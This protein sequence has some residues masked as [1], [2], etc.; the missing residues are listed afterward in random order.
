MYCAHCRKRFKPRPWPTTRNKF[1]S[2]RCNRDAWYTRNKDRVNAK[3]RQWCKD[4]RELRLEVQRRWNASSWGKVL[5][6]AW[7][8]DHPRVLTPQERKNNSARSTARR[9]LRRKHPIRR[10]VCRGP[11]RGRIEC[12]HKDGNPLNSLLTNL[13]WRCFYHH[14]LGHGRLRRPAPTLG[15]RGSSRHYE[16]SPHLP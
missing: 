10:C 3:T 8:L 9:R 13:E 4:N 12:H 5:K 11:H 7:R 1:C 6:N 2:I 15:V 16:Q 14:R